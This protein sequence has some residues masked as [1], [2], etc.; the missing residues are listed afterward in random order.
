MHQGNHK[1]GKS[2]KPEVLRD[3]YKHGKLREFCATHCISSSHGL[4]RNFQA[5][6]QNFTIYGDVQYN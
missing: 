2:G 1:P 6:S 5:S 4:C 3:F